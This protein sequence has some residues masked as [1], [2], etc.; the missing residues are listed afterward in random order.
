MELYSLPFKVSE[1]QAQPITLS[2]LHNLIKYSAYQ[3]LERDMSPYWYSASHK[4]VR[5]LCELAPPARLTLTTP[6][7]MSGVLELNYSGVNLYGDPG[8]NWTQHDEGEN[9]V[10]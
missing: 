8:G 2:S 4:P 1:F 10:S 9:L 3:G 7:R 6:D 5:S